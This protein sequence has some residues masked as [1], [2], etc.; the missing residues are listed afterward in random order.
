MSPFVHISRRALR[1]FKDCVLL[2]AS[3]VVAACMVGCKPE[4]RV[5]NYKPFFTGIEGARFGGQGPVVA[6]SDRAPPNLPWDR[7]AIDLSEGAEAG[8]GSGLILHNPDGSRRLVLASPMHVMRL[9]ERLLDDQED[10]LI[11]DQLFS[12]RT[13]QEFAGSGKG[14]QQAVEYLRQHRRDIAVLFARM[15]LAENSPTVIVD[16]PGDRVWVI[17]LTGRP[18]ENLR[19]TRLWVRLERGRWKFMW[20]N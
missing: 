4:E 9:L 1:R 20:V 18:S 14:P 3:F 15:P 17:R 6:E 13:L 7:G 11:I 16:Q 12:E 5:T 10:Q 19:F 8:T 2:A